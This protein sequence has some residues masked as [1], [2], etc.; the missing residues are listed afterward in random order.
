[1]TDVVASPSP[2]GIASDR[3]EAASGAVGTWYRFMRSIPTWAV[4]LLVVVWSIPSLGLFI[5][6][7]R[8]G[9]FSWLQSC[10]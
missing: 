5:N 8:S 10:C 7:W 1:M 6:S 9:L 2:A 4:W 3:P